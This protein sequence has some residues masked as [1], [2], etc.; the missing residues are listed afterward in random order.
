MIGYISD[1]VRDTETEVYGINVY[2]NE[3]NEGLSFEESEELEELRF[4]ES[5]SPDEMTDMEWSRL[6][7]LEE[8]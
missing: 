3:N 2:K 7:E 4:K 5:N 8:K 1:L 6:I